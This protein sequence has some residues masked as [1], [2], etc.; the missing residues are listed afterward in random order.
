M[1]PFRRLGGRAIRYATVLAAVLAALFLGWTALGRGMAASLTERGW[2]R[3]RSGNLVEAVG[4]FNKAEDRASGNP[5]AMAGLGEAYL[6]LYR[7][8]PS[9][10][11][12]L[13]KARLFLSRAQTASPAD[14]GVEIRLC[15]V[16]LLQHAG[17]PRVASLAFDRA[18]T[19]VG[20]HGRNP[21]LRRN[22]L[23][24][25]VD[26]AGIP[27]TRV[28]LYAERDRRE[29]A[30]GS[31]RYLLEKGQLAMAEIM[32]LVSGGLLEPDELL[33]T[34]GPQ[35]NVQRG[36]A[37]WMVASGGWERERERM[38]SAAPSPELA[39]FLRSVAEVLRR[40]GRAGEAVDLLRDY[41]RIFPN[42]A[43]AHVALATTMPVRRGEDWESAQY[44]YRQAIILAP[45]EYG[46]RLRYGQELVA[47]KDYRRALDQ[48]EPVAGLRADDAELY[49]SLGQAR[50]GLGLAAEAHEAY[51]R[52]A[53]LAPAVPLYRTAMERVATIP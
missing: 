53:A 52:A 46:Y 24:L 4:L 32:P 9:S 28:L 3:L 26:G 35:E 14:L 33:R 47:R 21:S 36:F 7:R 18:A 20:R 23:E 38:M 6:L 8:Q 10:D 39:A 12:L 41:L 37:E 50:E 34:F 45:L 2:E 17:D 1:K 49:Y 31:A 48:L 42:D 44:H 15:H 5:R 11:L 29:A 25:A 22:F 43:A 27:G 16:R 51:A 13:E 19:L 40:A 30:V